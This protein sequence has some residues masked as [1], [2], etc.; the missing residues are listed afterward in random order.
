MQRESLVTT[1]CQH[2]LTWVWVG[3]EVGVGRGQ[4]IKIKMYFAL[5][6]S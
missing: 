2:L 6:G 4:N 5:G 1:K 3:M